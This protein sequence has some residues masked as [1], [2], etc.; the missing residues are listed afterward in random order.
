MD[1]VPMNTDHA[2]DLAD[3]Q[4]LDGHLSDEGLL[5]RS[6]HLVS[7]PLPLFQRSDEAV[8]FPGAVSGRFCRA[9]DMA[10]VATR[11]TGQ[12]P[13]NLARLGRG[14]MGPASERENTNGRGGPDV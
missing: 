10:R 3:G 11:R 4:L 9:T 12:E 7:P 13:I 5:V 2:G 14:V 6:Q 1:G 8:H